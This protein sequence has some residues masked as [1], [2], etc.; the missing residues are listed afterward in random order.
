M[1]YVIYCILF[2]VFILASFWVFTWKWRTEVVASII[3]RSCLPYKVTVDKVACLDRETLLLR[4]VC[5]YSKN[6][7]ENPVVVISEI[8]AS[9]PTFSWLYWLLVPSRR[10]LYLSSL[11]LH[12]KKTSPLSFDPPQSPF[13]V[14]IEKITVK[15]GDKTQKSFVKQSGLLSEIL[16]EIFSPPH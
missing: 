13:L 4:N 3:E 14:S 9:S 10:P 11:E 2:F 5:L 8:K 7:P 16:L 12:V 1:R 15:S 6:D